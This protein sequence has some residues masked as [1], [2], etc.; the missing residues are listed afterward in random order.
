MTSINLRDIELDFCKA[1]DEGIGRMTLTELF[2]INQLVD[3]NGH[4]IEPICVQITERVDPAPELYIRPRTRERENFL[5]GIG[6][7][8]AEG[9]IG[10][11]ADVSNYQ[12]Y[13]ETFGY[14]HSNSPSFG[15]AE[16][17]GENVSYT[18][19]SNEETAEDE[20][21]PT[22]VDL[23]LIE[24]GWTRYLASFKRNAGPF[25]SRLRSINESNDDEYTVIDAGIAD[26]II[27]WGVLDAHVYG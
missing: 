26:I 21:E 15:P 10:Y 16:H 19:S 2:E 11:W 4:E 22:V 7:T 1:S 3:E 5:A 20:I 27:Q 9:G 18:V 8:A 25:V 24:R 17:G 14:R 12:W 6:I 23:D 13:T